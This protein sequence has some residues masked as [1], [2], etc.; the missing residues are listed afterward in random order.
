MPVTAANAFGASNG[1][2]TVTIAASAA[3]LS[4]ANGL[5]QP[6]IVSPAAAYA[7]L[8]QSFTYGITAAHRGQLPIPMA[9]AAPR[10]GPSAPPG[11]RR[12]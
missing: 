5:E 6:V 12:G 8:G 3:A 9:T 10:P 1:T 2:L 11:C 7:S 4:T